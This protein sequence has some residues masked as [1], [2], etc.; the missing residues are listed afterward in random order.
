MKTFR[1]NLPLAGKNKI[2]KLKFVLAVTPDCMLKSRQ[3]KQLRDTSIA[4]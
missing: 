1:D 3:A 4:R 2:W